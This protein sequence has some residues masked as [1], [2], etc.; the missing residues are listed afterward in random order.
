MKFPKMLDTE[1]REV[2]EVSFY[3]SYEWDE[4]HVYHD[5]GRWGILNQ[6]GCSC[7][8][9]EFDASSLQVFSGKKEMLSAFDKLTVE[10]YYGNEAE[11]GQARQNLRVAMKEYKENGGHNAS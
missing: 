7:T 9:F 8:Y 6:S 3:E 4:I 1:W 2:F 11:H 10:S 5:G